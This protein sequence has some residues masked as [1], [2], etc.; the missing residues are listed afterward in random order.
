MY[1]LLISYYFSI[2]F[3]V[4]HEKFGLKPLTGFTYRGLGLGWP[5]P[6]VRSEWSSVEASPHKQFGLELTAERFTPPDK[7][8]I[9]DMPGVHQSLH[10]TPKAW[11]LLVSGELSVRL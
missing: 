8:G 1:N 9:C 3:D 10:Q 7:L 11:R 4:L 2:L 6:C 5:Q